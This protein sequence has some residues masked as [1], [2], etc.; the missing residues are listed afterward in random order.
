MTVKYCQ[1]GYSIKIVFDILRL[2]RS[3]YNT[4]I[5]KINTQYND[6][7]HSVSFSVAM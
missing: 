7:S 4:I 5:N 2:N 3:D 1:L 6:L